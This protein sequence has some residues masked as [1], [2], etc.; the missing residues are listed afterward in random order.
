MIKPIAIYLPQFHPI[1]E[2]DAAWGEGFTEWTNVKKAK[3]LFEGHYQPH[4]PHD[5]LGYYNLLENSVLEKQVEI[6]KKYGIYGFAFYHYWFNGKRLLEKP[7]DNFLK[8][9]E[10]NFPFCLIWAN[11]PWSKR[12]DGSENEIIQPQIHSIQDDEIHMNF[13]CENIFSDKRY[14]KIDTKPIFIV[15]RTE[16]FDNIKET[17]KLWRRI[18]KKYGFRDLH[19]VRVESFTQ[20]I[21]PKK[22]D[23]DAA[24]E[25]APNKFTSPKSEYNKN[26]NCYDYSTSVFNALLTTYDYPIYRSVFP[27]WDNS[28][29]RGKNSIIYINNNLDVF[30]FYFERIIQYVLADKQNKNNFLFINAWNEWGEGCHIE[31]DQKNGFQYLEI[32]KNSISKLNS[33]KMYKRYIY[34]H[35]IL[36]YIGFIKIMQ[37]VNKF[38]LKKKSK[39]NF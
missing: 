38:F 12:W 25:F 23:F 17:V 2:N 32:I 22:I 1:P 4:I 30:K 21:I 28:P 39:H 6:A 24:M 11:E 15:Y 34:I 16:L 31:P 5:S 26:L 13:L 9:K 3:P 29:R 14:I 20:N 7:I 35:Q 27:S 8:N 18:A 10:I 37:F 19:L 33:N 36:Q